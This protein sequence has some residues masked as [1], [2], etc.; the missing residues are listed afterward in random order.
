MFSLLNEFSKSDF[1][2]K[3]FVGFVLE[4]NCIFLNAVESLIV[5]TPILS[6]FIKLTILELSV[7]V[8]ITC[9]GTEDRVEFLLF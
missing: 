5:D 3:R 7:G 6:K 9:A 2:L 4:K 1:I 8:K